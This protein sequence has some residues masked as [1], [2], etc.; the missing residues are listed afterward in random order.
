MLSTD[1]SWTSPEDDKKKKKKWDEDDEDEGSESSSLHPRNI[2]FSS[3]NDRAIKSPAKRKKKREAWPTRGEDEDD[4]EE[5]HGE[6]DEEDDDEDSVQSQYEGIEISINHVN[7]Y[8][9]LQKWTKEYGLPAVTPMGFFSTPY[10][11]MAPW[12]SG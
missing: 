9:W 3:K 10:A 8:E 2:S 1:V 12:M 5:I 6:V 11:L 7:L 4:E